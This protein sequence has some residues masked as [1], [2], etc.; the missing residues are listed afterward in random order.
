[1]SDNAIAC[2]EQNLK[3]AMEK[4]IEI[5]HEYETLPEFSTL[6][7]SVRGSGMFF[8]YSQSTRDAIVAHAK[9]SNKK[10]KQ[11]IFEKA[12]KA[13]CEM[14]DN[15]ISSISNAR[16]FL[17]QTDASPEEQANIREMLY[18]IENVYLPT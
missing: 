8:Q 10:L 15:L 5:Y 13:D 1:M 6:V 2:V 14:V 4:Y 18:R 9:E 7:R 16:I 17:A 12:V 3:D 11:G